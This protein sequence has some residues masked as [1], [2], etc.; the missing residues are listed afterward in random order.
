MVSSV[1]QDPQSMGQL[2]WHTVSL[3]CSHPPRQASG[4]FYRH[5]RKWTLCQ[6]QCVAFQCLF[7]M[8]TLLCS[9]T[10]VIHFVE[11]RLAWILALTFKCGGSGIMQLL[12]LSARDH[13]VSALLLLLVEMRSCVTGNQ[14]TLASGSSQLLDKIVR[15]V[16]VA[17]PVPTE[18]KCRNEPS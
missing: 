16:R 1:S 11:S 10:L 18:L 2:T 8:C 3:T 14:N 15:P 12:N 9:M 4:L 7:P 17:A 6:K 5:F 13:V